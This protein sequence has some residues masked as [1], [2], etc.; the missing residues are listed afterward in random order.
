MYNYVYIYNF[1]WI[2]TSSNKAITTN[3]VAVY[4]DN[5]NTKRD[6]QLK[7]ESILLYISMS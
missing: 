1:E 5:N 7:L 6:L 4:D 2:T 3:S